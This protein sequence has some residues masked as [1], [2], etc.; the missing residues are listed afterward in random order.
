MKG[1][2]HTAG[3]LAVREV[4]K[5]PLSIFYLVIMGSFV[6]TMIIY[7]LYN[8]ITIRPTSI[9]AVLPDYDQTNIKYTPNQL[10][11]RMGYIYFKL[12]K[13][14]GAT[15]RST[16]THNVDLWTVILGIPT[17]LLFG[18]FINTQNPTYYLAGTWIF[19]LYIS[20]LSHQ[21]LDTLTVAGTNQSHFMTLIKGKN[22]EKKL[23]IVP[24][25]KKFYQMT[26][27]YIFGRKTWFF[28]PEIISFT[29]KEWGRTG[30]GVWETIIGGKLINFV[31][32][33]QSL[34]T[35]LKDII[36]LF[37]IYTFI[38]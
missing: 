30:D 13:R 16:H 28:R 19:T 8:Y 15:H 2:T 4:A 36:I 25:D 1:K 7:F 27:I 35:K 29:D 14:R 23:S 32:N 20:I 6:E 10:S 9:G 3:A 38:F 21:F 11:T 22:K 24:F 34:L 5:L 31:N 33:Q 26:P 12:L 17:F 37:I 18:I